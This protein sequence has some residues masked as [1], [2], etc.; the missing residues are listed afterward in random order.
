MNEPANYLVR[1]DAEITVEIEVDYEKGATFA[2][3]Q[4]AVQDQ[5][6]YT[7]LVVNDVTEYEM[8]P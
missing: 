5:L 2:G 4:Q 7:G 6:G 3:L 8:V 1:F